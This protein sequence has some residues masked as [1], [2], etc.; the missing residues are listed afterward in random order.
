MLRRL[1]CVLLMIITICTSIN[2]A[3]A[4]TDEILII[5]TKHTPPFAIKNQDGS[6]SGI[7]IDLWRELAKD[8]D[9]RY[10]FEER[11]LQGLVDG[12][13]DKSL[14]AVVAALTITS[15]RETSFDF[16]H[17]FYSTGLSIAAITKGDGSLFKA[18][19]K[20]FS[21]QFIKVILALVILLFAIGL[22]VWAFERKRNQEQFGG[23]FLSGIA[24]GFWWSAVTMTTVGY[25]DKAPQTFWGRLLG[26]IWMF[27]AVIIISSFTATITSVLTVSQLE[28]PVNGP[29]DLPGVRVGTVSNSTAAQYLDKKQIV[30]TG[31]QTPLD[32]L[33]AVEK[34]QVDAM[35]YDA[36]ILKYLVKTQIKGKLRVLPNTFEGQDYGI[37]LPDSSE[38]REPLNRAMLKILHSEFWRETLRKYIGE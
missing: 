14:D 30:F 11:D 3:T 33:T 29:E 15:E 31:Y 26:L 8:L 24:S 1:I 12:L 20:I 17:P 23:G 16:T 4:E 22:L 9:I 38:F 36:P 5:G 25:G 18:L 35:V 13:N 21:L 37:G 10:K 27:T 34:G 19:R 6:W 7:T 32:G 28:S 2:I